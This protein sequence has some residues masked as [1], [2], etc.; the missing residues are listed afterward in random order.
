MAKTT[1]NLDLLTID[2]FDL[3]E[4]PIGASNLKGSSGNGCTV[5]TTCAP[6][7]C[8]DTVDEG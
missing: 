4:D 1:L 6:T 3:G 8:N 5:D 2:T 7:C